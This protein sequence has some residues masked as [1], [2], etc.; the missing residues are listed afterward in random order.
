[1]ATYDQV[2]H[3][4][5]S[6]GERALILNKHPIVLKDYTA[7]TPMIQKTY[8][9]VRDRVWTRRTGAFLYARP[10]MGKTRCA[11]AIR[12]LLLAEFPDSYVMCLS[13]DKRISSSNLGFVQDL[14]TSEDLVLGKRISAK[15][16]FLRLLTH[17][18][19]MVHSQSGNHVVLVIDEM[20]LLSEADFIIL[21]VLQNRL[22]QKNIALTTLGFAQP[23]ILHVR[24]ALGVNKSF[25]LIARFLAEPIVFDGCGSRE[26]LEFILQAY[27]YEKRYPEN[28]DWPYTRFFL[29][30]A[31]KAGFRLQNYSELIWSILLAAAEPLRTKTVPMEHL[32]RTIEH[33]LLANRNNDLETFRL[34]SQLVEK[35]VDASNLRSFSALMT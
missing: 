25:N 29:P 35:A 10:R 23:E 33:L 14:I 17:I 9:V 7:L 8:E 13:A 22:E 27:D 30:D 34:D 32:T 20:Q 2:Q 1:M 26:D 6:A 21:L 31:Y 18:E 12:R 15:E 28:S 19:T 5:L 11:A 4:E 16:A 3:L 24:T